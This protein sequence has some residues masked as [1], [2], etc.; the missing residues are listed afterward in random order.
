MAVAAMAY[1]DLKTFE[2]E[3][4]TGM[5]VGG[6][7]TWRY[8]NAI[9]RE[10]KTAP[11]EWQFTLISTKER[12]RSSPFGSGAGL[13]TQYHWYLMAHQFVR[14][15]DQDRYT[16]FMSGLKYKIAHKRPEWRAWSSGYDVEESER[17]R[18]RA[19]LERAVDR[20]RQ[21]P[22]RYASEFLASP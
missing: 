16:T 1:D 14:K 6:R 3:P 8:T 19:I 17:D 21:R 15:I 12:E 10:V 5:A 11:D 22:A 20:L 13:D 2:G 18:V 7:H 9:W 4:Y